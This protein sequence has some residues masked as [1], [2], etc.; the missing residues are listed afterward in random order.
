MCAQT[1]NEE[2]NQANELLLDENWMMIINPI[3]PRKYIQSIHHETIIQ[4]DE[5]SYLTKMEC[6]AIPC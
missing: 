6:C 4:A 1:E 3:H 2:K 5:Q